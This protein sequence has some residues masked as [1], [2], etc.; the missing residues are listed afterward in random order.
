MIELAA[1]TGVKVRLSDLVEYDPERNVFIWHPRPRDLFRSYGEWRRWNTRYAG[2]VTFTINDKG[3][4]RGSLF[5]KN[6]FA[7]RVVWA[8]THGA[9]PEGEIDHIDG[10]RGNNHPSNLRDVSRSENLR[11]QKLKCFN[12]S[13]YSG[14]SWNPKNKRWVARI[15]ERGRS[16]HIGCFREL[17]EAAAA[18]KLAEKHWGYHENHGRRT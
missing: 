14:V 7:H 4:R 8:L 11:N 17:E 18:R 12:T 3:Y 6:Y 2:K 10:N 15:N 13:G 16:R 1:P 9:W 5:K